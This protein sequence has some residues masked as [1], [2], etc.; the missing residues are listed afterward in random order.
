MK[1][2]SINVNSL[3]THQRRANITEI[4]NKFKPDVLLLCETKLNKNHNIQYAGFKCIRTDRDNAKQGGG[5][6]ILIKETIKFKHIQNYNLINANSLES[7]IIKLSMGNNKNLFIISAYSTHKQNSNFIHEL[8]NLFD[9][10]NL[11]SLENYY[12]LAADLNAKHESWSN[13]II[14]SRGTKLYNWLNDFQLKFKLKLL[15]SQFPSFPRS[16]SYLDII[17]AD[18]R[19]TISNKI[20]SNQLPNIPYDSDHDGLLAIIKFEQ[21]DKIEQNT[22]LKNLYNFKKT[23]WHTFKNY[24]NQNCETNISAYRNLEIEEI[25]ESIYSLEKLIRKAIEKNTPKIK[26]RNQT[27][28]YINS[29][30]KKLQKTKSFLITQIK[31]FYRNNLNR[32]SVEFNI[33]KNLLEGTKREL[34]NE[35]KK[36]INQYWTQKIAD[37]P[38]NNPSKTF[39]N[40]NQIFRKKDKLSLPDT[41]RIPSNRPI[42]LTNANIDPTSANKDQAGKFVFTDKIEKLNILASH[43]SLIHSQNDHMGKI[44]LTDL[45]I[46]ETDKLKTKMEE[47]RERKNSTVNFSI[48]NNSL[49]PSTNSFSLTNHK[50]VRDIFRKLNNKKSAGNDKIPNI[51]LKHLPKNITKLYT[52]IFNNALNKWYFPYKWKIAKIIAIPKKEKDPSLIENLRPISLLPN[53]GKI[54]EIII[55]KRLASACQDKNIIPETQFGF[56]HRHSTIHAIT[57]LTSDICWSLNSGECV[58]A[59]LIDVEK[60]FDTVWREGLIFKLLRKNFD[61]NLVKIIYN[62]IE[63]R[64]FTTTDQGTESSLAFKLKNGLQQGTVSAPILFNLYIS[65]ILNLYNLNSL[66]NKSALAFADDLIVYVKGKKPSEIEKQ[67]ESLVNDIHSYYHTWK[68]KININKCE[69]ILFRPKIS[70]ANRD[71]KKKW[72]NFQIK[73]NNQSVPHKKVVKYLGIHLDDRLLFNEHLRIQLKKARAAFMGLNRLFYSPHLKPKIKI[74]CYSLLIRPIITYGC[75]IW[76]NQSPSSM[77]LIRSFERKCLRA[78]LGKYRSPESEF[79]KYISNIKLYNLANLNRI[80]CFIIKLIRNH[81]SHITDISENS[82]ISWAV[83]PND[84]YFNNTLTSGFIP[85]EAFIYLDANGYIQNEN[86]IPIIYHIFRRKNDKRISFTAQHPESDNL[87]RFSRAISDRDSREIT[88]NK[89]YWWLHNSQLITGEDSAAANLS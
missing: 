27:E 50:E 74:Q 42:I 88:N 2:I 85:P 39:P 13:E 47:D 45:I 82:L 48:E 78:C 22:D 38:E 73:I 12:Y 41:I 72:K 16:N 79:Q 54:L 34:I 31:N 65:D 25:D 4:I 70:N 21:T 36:S 83:Y 19:L 55:T 89:K 44:Q 24:L 63:D 51:I 17:L 76:F 59:C 87:S 8:T 53:P 61:T 15:H 81:Y 28:N 3:I 1:I 67:L 35:F 30:I 49:C 11:D 84:G 43:F 57:K 5:T 26:I 60:A 46:S 75:S 71:V 86:K 37:I 40:I 10:L 64:S 68:L 7:T 62:M 56:R 69:T 77:E 18:S 9:T 14:N 32:N 52:I 23:N 58:G 29:K 80:D 33:L 20:N 66:K 6:I